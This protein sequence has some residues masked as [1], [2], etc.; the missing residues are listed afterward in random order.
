MA[1]PIAQGQAMM[2][3]EMPATSAWVSAGAGPRRSQPAKASAASAITAGTNQSVIRSTSA[4]TGSFAP[5]ASATS[6]MMRASTVSSPVAVTRKESA[7]AP[8][9]VPPVTAAPGAF[10]TGAGS[11]VSI[12][13]SI[14]PRPSVTVPSTATR[15]PGA[16]RTMSPSISA[17]T[18]ISVTWPPRSTRAVSGR[19]PI[20][21]R[22]ASPARPLARASSIR[23]SRIRVTIVAAASK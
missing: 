21:R 13:S 20:S 9:T 11:P 1:S 22:I 12:D 16:R 18:G 2:R 15:S 6:A 3:T 14:Q 7:E 4:C 10:S 8:F 17:A 5:C 19:S 23:P